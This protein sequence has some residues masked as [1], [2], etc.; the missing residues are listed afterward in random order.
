MPVSTEP[1]RINANSSDANSSDAN[2]ADSTRTDLRARRGSP[3]AP[4]PAGLTGSTTRRTE[5]AAAAAGALAAMEQQILGKIL[6]VVS[7]PGGA[8]S[9]L[10]RHLRGKPLAGPSLPLDVGQ[11]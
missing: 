2:R 6:Q 1:T 10:R 7:G 9:I 11:P 5:V 4:V 8:A 3:T